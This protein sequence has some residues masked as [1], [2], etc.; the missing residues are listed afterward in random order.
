[1]FRCVSAG[2]KG[3]S[4]ISADLGGPSSWSCTFFPK[5]S[6]AMVLLLYCYDCFFFPIFD[7]LFETWLIYIDM[8]DSRPFLPNAYVPDLRFGLCSFFFGGWLD[9]MSARCCQ[10]LSFCMLL[11][12]RMTVYTV[13]ICILYT[14]LLD[15]G[16]SIIWCVEHVVWLIYF[17]GIAAISGQPQG[18]ELFDIVWFQDLSVQHN[19]QMWKQGN[20]FRWAI[21]KELKWMFGGL[22]F[23]EL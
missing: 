19:L 15:C 1:M 23:M 5:N 21:Y 4:C 17:Q 9:L 7:K 6:I 11:R 8:M 10:I 3:S 2:P 12:E 16:C 18:A 13:Y 14:S 20:S 22:K